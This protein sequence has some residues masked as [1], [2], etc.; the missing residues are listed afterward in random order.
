MRRFLLLL[1]TALA[2]TL[3]TDSPSEAGGRRCRGG[4]CQPSAGYQWSATYR[5][6]PAPAPYP[7]PAPAPAPVLASPQSAPS[8][9]HGFTAWLNSVRAQHGR[10]PVAFDANLSYW[11]SV[12][13]GQQSAYGM[14][15]HVM[16][17]ARRQNSGMGPAHQVWP[18]W[19]SSPLHRD[20]L[21]DHTITAIGIS[22]SGSYWT[23]NAH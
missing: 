19:L 9:D 8:A 22:F 11:A 17:S 12:N 4:A 23:F 13:N 21:L 6:H 18:M 16:G 14:G 7:A 15:H 20:A 1:P 5:T 10:G 2:L 3:S